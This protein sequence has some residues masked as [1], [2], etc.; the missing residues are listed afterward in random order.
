MGRYRIE[1]KKS[2]A[3]ELADIPRRDLR[4]IVARIRSL[5]DD[6]RPPG[7]KKLS[8][9]EKYRI[10]RGRYRILYVIEDDVLIIY[11]VKIAHRRDVYR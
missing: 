1:V 11:V 10:R 7:S 4:L 9:Q 6:P 5:A 8:A 2:A 3:K